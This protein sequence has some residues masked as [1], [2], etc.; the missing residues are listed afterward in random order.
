MVYLIYEM[1]VLNVNSAEHK[2]LQIVCKSRDSLQLL[3]IN[4]DS[5]SGLRI[6]SSNNFQFLDERAAFCDDSNIR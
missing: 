5:I 2:T 3:H 1:S 6:F 4:F